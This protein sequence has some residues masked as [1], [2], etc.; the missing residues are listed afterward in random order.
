MQMLKDVELALAEITSD[1]K[2]SFLD[3]G[4]SKHD[5]KPIVSQCE[6]P[7]SN[8]TVTAENS[9]TDFEWS[10]T[11]Y[12]IRDEIALLSGSEP[13]DLDAQTS[14][15]ALGLD[16]ID[17]IKLSSR[18]KRRGINISVSMIMRNVT[19]LQM[20]QAS[21]NLDPEAEDSPKLILDTY[22]GLL[23]T[24]L[25]ESGFSMKNVEAVFPPTPFQEAVFADT[26]ETGFSRYLNQEIF[27]VRSSVDIKKLELA[28]KSVI[29]QSPILR[30]SCFAVD[31]P[32]IP[33]SYAQVVHRTGRSSIR[34]V[35]VTPNDSIDALITAVAK[36]DRTTALGDIPFSLTFIEHQ[37]GYHMVL[38]L[39]HALYDGVS[40]SLLHSDIFEA[41]HDR[42]SPRLSYRETLEHI[43]RSSDARASQYW[44]E[45][46]SGAKPSSFLSHIRTPLLQSQVNRI[47]RCS[48]ISATDIRSF[49]KSQGI[50]IQA[51]GQLCWTL[52]LG[53]HLKTLEVTFGVILSGRDTE[54]SSEVMLPTM[55]T[56]VVRSV[57]GGSLR[58]MLHDMQWS[59]GNAV[60]YQH[61]PLRKTLATVKNQDQKLFD[62][63]F[64]VQRKSSVIPDDERLYSSIGGKSSVEVTRA[65]Y[66]GYRQLLTT[67]SFLFAWRWSSMM[68]VSA[69][70]VHARM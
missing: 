39:S 17:A 11:A 69:G 5:L 66:Q 2:I 14:I 18:L 3:I 28:W 24:Y 13:T 55:N 56:I 8:E 63:L 36:H 64:L 61:F 68:I 51:L 12:S 6:N 57:I 41:Y 27:V 44:T 20:T 65:I 59:C 48:S 47:E 60:Q 45:Y 29:D 10:V 50:S 1:S 38:T 16:S 40:L 26:S 54:Q 15:F 7:E 52:L 30:T 25:Q 62:S 34:H 49:A 31:D 70:G 22:E 67:F 19:I 32:D 46:V 58:Q 35:T 21:K 33:F 43:L 23:S 4:I 37:N 42:F 53:Y 9:E